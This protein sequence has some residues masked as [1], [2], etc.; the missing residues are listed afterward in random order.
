MDIIKDGKVSVYG[1][2]PSMPT[3]NGDAGKNRA[4]ECGYE[5]TRDFVC[6]FFRVV[7]VPVNGVE[8]KIVE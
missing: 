5:L 8:S 2:F 4:F 7:R 1:F 6:D 3:G